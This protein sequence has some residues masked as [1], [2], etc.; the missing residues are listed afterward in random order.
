[1]LVPTILGQIGRE[2]AAATRSL[3]EVDN[4]LD[5]VRESLVAGSLASKQ[6]E[7]AISDSAREEASAIKRFSQIAML[8]AKTAALNLGGGVA[9]M[10]GMKTER[11]EVRQE[12]LLKVEDEMASLLQFQKFSRDEILAVSQKQIDLEELRIKYYSQEATQDRVRLNA[13]KEAL[14][15][16]LRNRELFE[17]A[18]KEEKQMANADIRIV[19]EKLKGRTALA[20][21]MRSELDW[22]HQINAA[23]REGRVELASS[24]E[25]QKKLEQM[26]QKAAQKRQTTRERIDARTEARRLKSDAEKQ[27]RRN[28]ELDRS[29]LRGARG[30]EGSR[31]E[32]RRRANVARNQAMLEQQKLPVAPPELQ[33]LNSIAAT[34]Q[35]IATNTRG[36]LSVKA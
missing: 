8:A 20:Q 26:Q 14:G 29:I 33:A 5:N 17:L 30:S 11:M 31:L 12:D 34:N 7:S 27:D 24:L 22:Q 13:A 36:N 35:I 28:A 32:E 16:E 1:M 23:Y 4:E 9:R 21:M 15:V 19:S 3:R 18:I 10:A 25:E 6:F 2:T